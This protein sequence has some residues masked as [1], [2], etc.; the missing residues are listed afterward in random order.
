MSAHTS[1]ITIF[2]PQYVGDERR[3]GHRDTDEPIEH[4]E[5]S[6]N[7]RHIDR[8]PPFLP[9]DTSPARGQIAVAE[10]LPSPEVTNSSEG[11]QYTGEPPT[12]P[13]AVGNPIPEETWTDLESETQDSEIRGWILETEGSE[14]NETQP[15]PIEPYPDPDPPALRGI[16]P[17]VNRKSSQESLG[18][19]SSYGEDPDSIAS[20]DARSNFYTSPAFPVWDGTLNRPKILHTIRTTWVDGEIHAL[21]VT[22]TD[23]YWKGFNTSKEELHG[24]ATF[25]HSTLCARKDVNDHFESLKVGVRLDNGVSGDGRF[26]RQRDHTLVRRGLFLNHDAWPALYATM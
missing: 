6:T 22:D 7:R 11:H 5:P 14:E 23:F 26:F 24:F 4:P 10:Q 12:G 19:A 20:T 2:R 18:P 9:V 13:R 3:L 1:E 25:I 17:S 8:S 16:M 21:N 15:P